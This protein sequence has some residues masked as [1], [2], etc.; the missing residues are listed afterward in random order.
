M[1]RLCPLS[2]SYTM[3]LTAVSCVLLAA[4]VQ[5]SPMLGA[6]QCSWGPSYWCANI[7]QVENTDHNNNNN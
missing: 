2:V 6:A 1:S 5:S 4:L 3:F 7:P